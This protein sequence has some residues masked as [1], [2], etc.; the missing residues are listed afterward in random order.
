MGVVKPGNMSFTKGIVGP[1]DNPALLLRAADAAAPCVIQRVI[2]GLALVEGHKFDLRVL[3][4][5]A[6]ERF[7]AHP[8]WIMRLA[9]LPVADSKAGTEA[10]QA[11][12]TVNE[13]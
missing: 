12:F 8:E 11:F 13:Q 4:L 5:C 9:A 1:A 3:V 2:D 7:W 10:F 6:K